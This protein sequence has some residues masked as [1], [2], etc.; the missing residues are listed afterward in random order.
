MWKGVTTFGKWQHTETKVLEFNCGKGPNLVLAPDET[1]S[2]AEV[3][4]T[5]RLRLAQWNGGWLATCGRRNPAWHRFMLAATRPEH[6]TLPQVELAPGPIARVIVANRPK[7]RGGRGEP[8]VVAWHREREPKFVELKGPGDKSTAQAE[9]LASAF[10]R[11]DLAVDDF[12]LLEWVFSDIA[13]SLG[14]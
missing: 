3:E 9:W 11:G 12:L 8:D 10:D 13:E 6:S 5:R 4:T 14:G 1:M 2:A 7:R